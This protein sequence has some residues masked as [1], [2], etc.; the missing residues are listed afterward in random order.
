MMMLV[1]WIVVGSIVRYEESPASVVTVILVTSVQN[2]AVEE[3]TVS[4]LTLKNN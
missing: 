4:W 1:N 3:Q 2:V